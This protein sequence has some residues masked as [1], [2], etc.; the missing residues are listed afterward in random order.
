M[1]QTREQR[2]QYLKDWKTNHPDYMPIQLLCANCNWIK[3]YERGE[4]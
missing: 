2:L 3:K 4:S 1:V